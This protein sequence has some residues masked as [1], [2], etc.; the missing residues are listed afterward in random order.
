MSF[1]KGGAILKR[2]IP[3]IGR[4]YDMPMSVG[5]GVHFSF[6]P[7]RAVEELVKYGVRKTFGL[8][9]RRKHRRCR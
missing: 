6:D 7:N 1:Q 9:K 8:G 3:I 2:E 4:H 5:S